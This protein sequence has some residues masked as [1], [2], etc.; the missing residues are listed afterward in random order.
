MRLRGL[1]VAGDASIRKRL[2]RLIARHEVEVIPISNAA[3]LRER[4]T[5]EDFDLALIHRPLLAEHPEGLVHQIRE[6]PN[7]P[8]VI[9]LSDDE[10]AQ[11]RAGIVASG[12][13]AALNLGLT[14]GTLD[15][16][17]D[18]LILRRREEALR[19]FKADRPDKRYR[20]NDFIL[21]SPAMKNFVAMVRR[22]IS[23]ESPLLIIGETGVGKE[24]LARATHAEGLRANG[25]F[26]A[27]N[28]AALPENLLESELFGHEQGAFTGATRQRRGYFELA[29]RGTIFLD[30]IGELPIHLQAKLL[31][32]LEDR[33][34]QRVGGERPIPVDVRLMAAANRD[35]EAEMHGGAFRPDLYYR[36]AVVTLTIPPLRQ[37]SEDIVPLAQLYLQH[38]RRHL[39]RPVTG[40]LPEALAALNSHT[41]PGNVRELINVIERAV[42]ICSGHE[43]GL[44]DL[45]RAITGR[46]LAGQDGPL[47]SKASLAL[48][49][50][51]D[52]S[53]RLLT[54][55][56][57]RREMLS[58]FEKA[59]LARL[60]GQTGGRVGDTAR[61]AG[62][63]ERSLYDLMRRHGLR[64][65]DFRRARGEEPEESE[66]EA[67][68][69]SGVGR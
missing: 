13:L 28:C 10:N 22:V 55:K 45:P 63:N 3:E 20:L 38:F 48:L 17:L 12:C 5:H 31:R 61:L 41:W 15:K 4:L 50:N 53:E 62:I 57:A 9:V 58:V 46:I 49:L 56:D 43:I 2:G 11:D 25:P 7:Q 39:G 29:H 19:R 64:K 6:L 47:A 1:L 33:I 67:R 16:A 36:L 52:P 68:D 18:A 44:E 30:E 37:R 69:G 32:V 21:A 34:V 65:E 27:V 51:A 26:I 14:D 23:S 59:Y 42:L 54:L 35:L 8:D 66:R 24:R 60:L 40:I